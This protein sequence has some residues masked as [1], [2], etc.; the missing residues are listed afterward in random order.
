[1]SFL[2]KKH[3]SLSI[4]LLLLI[5]KPV[6]SLDLSATLNFMLPFAGGVAYDSYSNQTARD[7]YGEFSKYW[8]PLDHIEVGTCM[9][10]FG[11]DRNGV[12]CKQPDG[13]W[14]IDD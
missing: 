10:Y 12:A 2:L 1:M 13:S 11:T 7:K 3:I 8:G 14:K 6:N 5:Y 9:R 4:L